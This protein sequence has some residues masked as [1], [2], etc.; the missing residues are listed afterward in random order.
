MPTGYTAPVKDGEITEFNEFAWRCARAFGA[1]ILM[2]EEP[3]DK[4]IDIPDH[5][6][7]D[8]QSYNE[9]SLKEA[10]ERLPAVEAMTDEEAEVAA[11][12]ERDELE[13]RQERYNAEAAQAKERY[14]AMLEKVRAWEP[15]SEDH[16][17]LKAFMESQLT[18]SIEFDG[19]PTTAYGDRAELSG[20]EWREREIERLKRGIEQDEKRIAETAEREESRLEWMRQLR[21]SVGAPPA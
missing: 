8:P 20:P 10:I 7:P 1:M 9:K 3:L 12:K 14:E 4:K 21:D 18:E 6:E 11:Q 2:R 16:A 13:K 19:T 5:Y 15:P 17:E